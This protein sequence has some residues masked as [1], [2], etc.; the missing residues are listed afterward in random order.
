MKMLQGLGRKGRFALLTFM[1]PFIVA[2]IALFSGRIQSDQWVSLIQLLVP[3]T[4][5]LFVAGN[6]GEHFVNSQPKAP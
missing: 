5:G 6:V 4:T 3:T 1:P 2:T